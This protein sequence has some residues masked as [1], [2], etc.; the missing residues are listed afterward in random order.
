MKILKIHL[1]YLRSE[2]HYQFLLLLLKLFESYPAV[3]AI[4][5]VLL[6]SI[7]E[8]VNIEG[9]LVD[10]VRS[11]IYTE[12]IAEADR[13]VDRD[14]AG[15]NA[16]I[17]SALRHFD[18]AIVTAARRLEIRFKSFRGEIEKKAYGEESAAVKIL[19][20]DLNGVYAP[21]VA[22][23]SLVPW[24]AEL[25]A[26][27]AEFERLFILR[28]EELAARPQQKLRDVRR[29]ID[30]LYRRAV[31]HIDAYSALNGDA[32]TAQFVSELNSEVTYFNEHAHRHA[33]TDIDSAVVASIPDQ[34]WKD[35]PVVLLPDVTYE[36][37]EL[38]FT[39][40]YELSY[41]DNNRPGTA[42]LTIHGKGRFRGTKTVSFN[43]IAEGVK[44]I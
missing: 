34:P 20:T 37:K 38:V 22:T 10:A 6:N 21:Q 5:S 7:R 2:A 23:L 1:E 28:N 40:D 11:S 4:V 14:L 43:I 41:R 17:E 29:Q 9:Q 32:L 27:Q 3:A 35:R 15:I 8:L 33:K 25:E 18:P 42:S 13:R 26:A 31:E 12:Q 44:D 24:V 30:I 16:A 19:L 36:G 39:K